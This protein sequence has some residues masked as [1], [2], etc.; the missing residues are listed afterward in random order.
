MRVHNII[1]ETKEF[2]KNYE[3]AIQSVPIET[4]R[5]Y[6]LSGE[7]MLEAYMIEDA[8]GDNVMEY[9]N[10]LKLIQGLCS[11]TN[12]RHR[13]YADPDEVDAPAKIKKRLVKQFIQMHLENHDNE[14]LH[15]DDVIV[16]E[17]R[18]DGDAIEDQTVPEINDNPPANEEI[19]GDDFDFEALMAIPGPSGISNRRNK[20]ATDINQEI[21]FDE[22]LFRQDGTHVR[23]EKA[24]KAADE[25]QLSQL[26]SDASITSLDLEPPRKKKLF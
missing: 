17:I 10:H 5:R 20:P 25:G 15:G 8:D 18:D 13:S 14:S 16:P 24:N 9:Y 1:G 21:I 19:D 6:F 22:E 11:T 7:R 23:I 2:E 12:T 3:L 26:S 4:I